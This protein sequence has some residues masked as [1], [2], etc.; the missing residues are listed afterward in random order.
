MWPTRRLHLE[1]DDS[2]YKQV[3][4][5]ELEPPRPRKKARHRVNLFIYVEAGVDG[6]ASND[7]ES[8]DENDDLER[9]IVAHN[10]D[11]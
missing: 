11:F 9:F 4:D 8:D 1:F 10:I 7:K 3:A 2:E 6:D 5:A